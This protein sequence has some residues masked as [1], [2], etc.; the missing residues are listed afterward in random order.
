MMT[1]FLGTYKKDDGGIFLVTVVILLLI[2]AVL[3]V[4]LQQTYFEYAYFEKMYKQ[5]RG[6]SD[7]ITRNCTSVVCL[8]SYYS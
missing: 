6:H 4:I 7:E 3:G 8:F 2:F 5:I 1:Y